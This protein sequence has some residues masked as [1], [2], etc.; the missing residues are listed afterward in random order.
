VK[1][2]CSDQEVNASRR[3]AGAKGPLARGSSSLWGSVYRYG[4]ARMA[5]DYYNRATL[6]DPKS[7]DSPGIRDVY[8]GSSSRTAAGAGS[9]KRVRRWTRT[10]KR[11]RDA[12]RRL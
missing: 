1:F 5:L 10:D 12:L 7:S 2:G 11:R 6:D 3:R 4:C 9:A 8:G